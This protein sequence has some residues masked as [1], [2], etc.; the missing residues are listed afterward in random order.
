[1]TTY[2]TYQEAKIA[3][4]ECEIYQLERNGLFAHCD[5]HKAE[6]VRFVEF[7]SD[8]I[9]CNPADYCMTVEKFLADGYKFVEG[10]VVFDFGDVVSVDTAFDVE[11]Y[12][13]IDKRDDR[14]YILRA[15]ALE[16]KKPRTKV[17]YVKCEFD[18]VSDLVIA[19]ESGEVFYCDN[20]IGGKIALE[21]YGAI[22]MH[23]HSDSLYRR[24]ETLMT[25]R[26]EF[27]DEC[28]KLEKQ[29]AVFGKAISNKWF[30][31]MYDSGKFKL[32]N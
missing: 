5:H 17:E 7:D 18:K 27:I 1:M 22:S 16:E 8:G 30:E 3:N 12:N 28:K 31:S 10:D 32:V 11:T 2:N 21:M 29:T 19:C 6:L 20:S 13:K 14:R 9:K 25:E 24:I 4:P 23:R 15:A 26:E